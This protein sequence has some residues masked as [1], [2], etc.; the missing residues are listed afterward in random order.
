[1]RILLVG[2]APTIHT[3][4]WA[5]HFRDRGDA[6][7]ISS[8]R[9]FKIPGVPVYT[10][11]TYGLG[12]PGYFFGAPALAKL[13][14]SFKPD[15]I[16]AHHITSYG[17]I[18]ALAGV[19]PLVLSAWGDDVLIDPYT[20]RLKRFFV[21]YAVK[22]ADLVTTVAE[23]MN[24]GIFDLHV[25]GFT[26]GVTEVPAI[27]F[28]V[29]LE[30]FSLAAPR[31]RPDDP[32]R[33]ICIRH[34]EPLYDIGTLIRAHALARKAGMKL[35][36][37]LIG[38][39][40]QRDELENLC[41]ELGVANEISFLGRVPHPTLPGRLQDADIFVSPALSDGNNVSLTEAMAC[42]CFPIA[43]EIPANTQWIEHGKNGYLYPASDAQALADCIVKAAADSALL[44]SALA[45]NRAIVEERANW[46]KCVRQMD[47]LY[48]R[49]LNGE[50]QP[51]K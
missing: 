45:E 11:P 29:N 30:L 32:V 39:G 33:L 38:E 8:F 16:H 18:A 37:T 47:E 23:H 3:R 34:L 25:N 50:G 13:C 9:P 44:A 15:I 35:R 19:K 22:S 46:H 20:S 40:W 43:T 4:R 7:M 28:G 48:A 12:K 1:M 24:K 49:V 21:R 14:R 5:E 42:G 41:R 10:L 17:F 31:S 36:T 27:T 6:V 51:K 26:E 2:D